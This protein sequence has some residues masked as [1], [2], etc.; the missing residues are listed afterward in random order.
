[1][2]SYKVNGVAFTIQP[3]TG[4]WL[5][6]EALGID[7]NGHPVYPGVREFEI[8]WGLVSPSEY[9]QIQNFYGSVSN[10]GTVAVT[11]PMYGADTWRFGNYSG[12]SL[13]EP[14]PSEFFNEYYTDVVMLV[15][16]INPNQTVMVDP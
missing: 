2:A 3:T 11:L 5:S 16:N 8:R 13:N 15:T 1:M 14:E 4:R 10:T 12:C 9:F 6:R 7:G